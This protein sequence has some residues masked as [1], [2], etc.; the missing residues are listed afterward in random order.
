MNLAEIKNTIE[1]F[2]KE[3]ENKDL[4]IWKLNEIKQILGNIDDRIIE[5]EE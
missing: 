1:E 2:I 4:K 5:E 3:E